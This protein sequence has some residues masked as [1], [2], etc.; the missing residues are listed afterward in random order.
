VGLLLDSNLHT[1]VRTRRNKHRSTS[2]K[3]GT[4]LKTP[5]RDDISRK[6]NKDQKR[7]S[8]YRPPKSLKGKRRS[9]PPLPQERH[10]LQATH[11]PS[12][13]FSKLLPPPRPPTSPTPQ[14]SKRLSRVFPSSCLKGNRRKK[15]REYKREKK[16]KRVQK[17]NKLSLQS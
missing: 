6:K 12:Y 1:Y 5:R 2:M 3:T 7:T 14:I 16:K 9:H 8:P 15:K 17:R 11:S 10:I 4:I 13:T